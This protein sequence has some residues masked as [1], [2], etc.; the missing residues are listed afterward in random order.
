MIGVGILCSGQGYQGAGMFDLLA[1]AAE[2]DRVFKA[3]KLILSGKDPRDLVHQTN[4]ALHADKVGQILC[5]TQAMAAWAVVSSKLPP[6]LVVAGYSVG[7]LA[8]WGVTRCW[9]EV[10]RRH[11]MP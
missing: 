11:S 8:A 9:S 4:D 5:C 2:A 6:P 7:E 3:A 10:Q 1:D